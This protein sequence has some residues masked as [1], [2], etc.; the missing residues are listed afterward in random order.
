VSA[1]FERIGGEL[2]WQGRIAGVRVERFRHADGEEVEREVVS[3]P[4]AVAIVAHDGR[5]VWMVRQP[6]EAVG[7]P[8]LLEIPAGK[9]DVDGEPPLATARREL[10]EEI[11]RTAAE[12]RELVGFYASPG[13]SDEL[14]H[15]FLATGLAD[16]GAAHVAEEEERIEVVPWPLADLDA[17]IAQVRDGKSLVGLLWLRMELARGA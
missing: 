6:R 12:W 11:G 9:L 5:H 13:F 10:A 8:G 14:I 7:E 1:P 3:H 16:A 4:G 15:V 17:L 2:V